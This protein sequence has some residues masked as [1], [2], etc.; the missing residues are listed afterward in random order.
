[1]AS[2]ELTFEEFKLQ[3]TTTAIYVL[4]KTLYGSAVELKAFLTQSCKV[5]KC[6]KLHWSNHL[7]D[8]I[9][10]TSASFRKCD[11]YTG[12]LEYGNI[13]TNVV[14][15]RDYGYLERL[16]TEAKS[17]IEE[18]E[19]RHDV[20]IL[21][22]HTSVPLAEDKDLIAA[23]T[24]MDPTIIAFLGCCG[25]NTHYGPILTMSYLLPSNKATP[26]IAFYQRQV[27]IDEL[28]DTSLMI[29]LQ[30]YLHM[31]SHQNSYDKKEV[32]RC[33]FG[34]AKSFDSFSSTDPT[35]FINDGDEK[36]SVQLLLDKC[37]LTSEAVPL[38]CMQLALYNPLVVYSK[39]FQ[40]FKPK[41][42]P[43]KLP[44]ILPE[45]SC[46]EHKIDIEDVLWQLDRW[47][48][49]ITLYGHDRK[50]TKKLK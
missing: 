9:A 18:H 4:D 16:I 30:Y 35:V 43:E 46:L 32:A 22:G 5:Y 10:E 2:K 40:S 6:N 14:S 15:I 13:D 39:E 29:G 41:P 36:N 8:T 26:I 1:M 12:T 37:D 23:F 44:I 50:C 19:L 24:K 11:H 21:L 31:I 42:E 48:I 25:G 45:E 49:K 7:E 47:R 38:S 34:L 28:K 17:S 33:A 20:I 27:Y 3:N